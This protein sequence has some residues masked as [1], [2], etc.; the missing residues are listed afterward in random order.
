MPQ[1]ISSP[2]AAWREH[3]LPGASNPRWL[4]ESRSVSRNIGLSKREIFGL[5]ILAHLCSRNG[6][7]WMVGYDPDQGEPNDGYITNGES[8]IRVEHKLINEWAKQEVLE[9]ILSTYRINAEQGQN[10]GSGRVLLIHPNKAPA[11]GDGGL[12]KISDLRD[13][14]H[15]LAQKIG[16]EC[17]FDRVLTMQQCVRKGSTGVFHLVQHYPPVN[18]IAQVDFDYRTGAADVPVCPIDL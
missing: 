18:G 17:N 9:E 8:F 10:Y 3:V 2:E 15:D 12:I 7:E 13:H 6:V 5:V 4:N 14:I 11:H 16:V 1:W